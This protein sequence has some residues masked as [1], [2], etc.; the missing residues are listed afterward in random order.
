MAPGRISDDDERVPAVCDAGN[1]LEN[2]IVKFANTNAASLSRQC[3]LLPATRWAH[4]DIATASALPT[5]RSEVRRAIWH[6]QARR[7]RPVTALGVSRRAAQTYLH[8]DIRMFLRK[9]RA[10]IDTFLINEGLACRAATWARTRSSI[11]IVNP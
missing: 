2:G 9:L 4:R 7:R 11:T 5:T 8:T 6:V 10:C 1:C 3:A